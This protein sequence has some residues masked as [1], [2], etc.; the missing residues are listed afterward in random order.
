MFRRLVLIWPAIIRPALIVSAV[1]LL[2]ACSAVRLAY[3]NLPE[4]GYWWIDGYADLGE[5]Q[6]LQLR[7]DLSRLH[8]WHRSNELPRIADLLRQ[9]QRDALAD[10]SAT[11]LCRIYDQLREHIDVV[12]VQAEPAALTLAMSLTPAQIQHIEGKFTT[13]NTQW[14]RDWASGDRAKRLEKRLVSAIDRAEQFYGTLD[15]KQRAVLQAGLARSSWDPQRSFPERLRRQQDLLQTLRTISG[16]EGTAR[17]TAQQ[18]ANLLRSYLRRTMESPDPAFRAYAQSTIQENCITYAQLHNSTSAEQ[19]ARA[20]AR[21]AAY[22][23]DARELAG[24]P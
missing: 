20:V 16:A 2:G 4:V 23:R 12:T 6:S 9:I 21:I 3:S 7:N 22:E 17:P 15:D 18:S 14:R 5:T 10:T 19:R 8:D 11:D 1:L 13:R 24:Q